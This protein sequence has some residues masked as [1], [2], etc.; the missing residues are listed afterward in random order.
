MSDLAS[1]QN[2][3][4]FHRSEISFVSLSAASL[5]NWVSVASVQNWK[6]FHRSEISF[7]FF[8]LLL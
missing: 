3:K 4:L 6:L 1:V 8:Q 2:W 7:V 5:G